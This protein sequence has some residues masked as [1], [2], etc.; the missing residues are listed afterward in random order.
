[1]AHQINLPVFEGPFDLLLHLVKVNEME[2]SDI[3]VAKITD[4]YL[5]TIT[6]MQD[7]DL[8]V[9]GD[10]LVMAATLIN[11]KV[12]ALLP[13]LP[14]ED[15]EEE[16]EDIAEIMSAKTLMEQLIEY[17]KFKELSVDLVDRQQEQMKLFFR[18]SLLPAMAKEQEQAPLQSELGLMFDCFAR[19]LKFVDERPHHDIAFEPFSVEQRV[20]VL[21]DQLEAEESLELFSLFKSCRNKPDMI[22]TL[23]ALLEMSRL[24]NIRLEQGTAFEEVFIYT[25]PEED[26]LPPEEP[27]DE[28]PAEPANTQ[29]VDQALP[30]PVEVAAED[31][32]AETQETGTELERKQIDQAT[33]P[34]RMPEPVE[35]AG[36]QITPAEDAPEDA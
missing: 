28:Q 20:G 18:N 15:D 36:E 16:G 33:E 10:F 35:D 3:D 5:Q 25:R 22:V 31:I 29:P 7:L 26:A 30:G 34:V 24:R 14:G 11:I 12:R 9:A 21:R 19:V 1:M 32:D 6:M 4:Q 2:I 23:L 17:R 27:D 13:E 8:E